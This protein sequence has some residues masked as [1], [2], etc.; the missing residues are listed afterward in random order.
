M[1][2]ETSIGMSQETR[3]QLDRHRAPGHA[4]MDDVLEGMMKMLPTADEILEDGCTYHDCPYD[5]L[6][7]QRP[8]DVGG[9]I[10]FFHTT[11]PPNDQELWDAN[12]FCSIECLA[13][14]QAEVEE[15][16]AV[17]PDRL[18][19]GGMDE[20]R[21]EVATDGLRLFHEGEAAAEGRGKEIGIPVPLDLVGEDRHGNEYDYHG[22][23]IYIE[24]AGQVR[25]SG[26]IDDIIREETHTAV[27]MGTDRGIEM[28]YHPDDERREKMLDGYCHWYDQECPA[29]GETLRVNESMEGEIECG[30]CGEV[31]DRAPVP[32]ENIPDPVLEYRAER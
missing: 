28:A 2:A 32:E 26:V 19:I 17:E 16:A 15:A 18:I 1:P 13:E 3:D 21:M 4:S 24:N 10:Q 23:P 27:Y 25:F 20:L 12:Y 7:A 5:R 31:A 8:E 6:P 29:C 22:E 14:S 9:V 11:L 30:E